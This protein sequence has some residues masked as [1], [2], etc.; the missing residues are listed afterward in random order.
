ML[1]LRSRLD[2]NLDAF[3]QVAIPVDFREA[4]A[5]DHAYVIVK[6]QLVEL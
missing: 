6:G 3:L 4:S 2:A 1:L 5:I